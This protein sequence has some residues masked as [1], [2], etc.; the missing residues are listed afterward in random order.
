MTDDLILRIV[1]NAKKCKGVRLNAEETYIL[2]TASWV[3]EWYDDIEER[4][5]AP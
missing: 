4:R 3:Q 5:S 2:A 1:Q